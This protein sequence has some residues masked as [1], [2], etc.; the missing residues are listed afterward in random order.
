MVVLQM[1]FRFLI[2]MALEAGFRF[3]LRIDD[4]LA[5]PTTGIDVQAAGTVTGFATTGKTNAVTFTRNFQPGMLRQ[6]EILHNRF[7]TGGALIH[8]HELRTGNDWRRCNDPF[9]GRTGNH[10]N[11]G[12]QNADRGD[13]QT[14]CRFQLFHNL[15]F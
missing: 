9:H 10:K 7:V 5:A 15:S 11:C 12:G 6:F 8:S 13:C 1:K 2:E 4:E 14:R 3:L